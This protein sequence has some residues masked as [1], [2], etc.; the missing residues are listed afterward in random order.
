MLRTWRRAAHPLVESLW[1]FW[2]GSRLP[3][4]LA[5]V[6]L[7]LHGWLA[8]TGGDAPRGVGEGPGTETRRHIS[9]S[10]CRA[11]LQLRVLRAAWHLTGHSPTPL[12][13]VAAAELLCWEAA[14]GM[15]GNESDWSDACPACRWVTGSPERA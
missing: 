5:R 13:R 2:A 3:R 14:T 8:D 6:P 1:E 11:P 10:P 4:G 9:P 7:T 15:L 12:R